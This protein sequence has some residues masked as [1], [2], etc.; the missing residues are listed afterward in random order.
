M[1]EKTS[2][3]F[4]SNRTFASKDQNINFF[5]CAENEYE[6]Q[7]NLG[8]RGG[9]VGKSVSNSY[10]TAGNYS[11]IQ[12]VTHKKGT[13]QITQSSTVTEN[14]PCANVSCLNGGICVDGN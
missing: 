5:S 12:T 8:D 7:W 10:S 1:Q 6:I 3:C 4:T 11:V 13:D 9:S 14:D 2:A